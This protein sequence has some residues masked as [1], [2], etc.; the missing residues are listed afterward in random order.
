MNVVDLFN[1]A[2]KKYPDKLAII[3]KNE[4]INFSDLASKVERTAAY[5]E[6]KGIGQGDRVLVFVPMSIDL[7]RIVLALFSRGATAVFLDQWVSK[8]RMELCCEIADCKGF[9]G[10]LKSRIFALFSSEL[11]RIPLKLKMKGM[12]QK[13]LGT[14]DLPSDHPALITFTTG[15]TGRPK[16]ANR[17]HGF[18]NEQFDALLDEIQPKLEDVDMP[19]LPIVLFM[20]LGFGCTSVIADLKMTKPHKMQPDTILKQ[21]EENKVNRITASPFV[22]SRLSEHIIENSVK[23]TGI[24]KIFTG[25]APVFPS[26]A[27]VFSKAFPNTDVHIV[28]GSTEVEPISSLQ[29]R[30]LVS[31]EQEMTIGLPVGKVYHKTKIKI[32]TINEGALPQ[33]SVDDLRDLEVKEGEIG[34]IIVS[35][36]HVLKNYY[37]SEDA[38][39]KNKIVVN[40]T[41]W[42]RTGDSGRLIDHTLFLNGRCSQL[43]HHQDEVI[44]PFIVENQLLEIEGVTMGT[45]LKLDDQLILVLETDSAEFSSGL[46]GVPY[47]EV[48]FLDQIPRDPRHNSKIDY[49]KLRSIL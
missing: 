18:L 11:R 13:G 28:Y 45:L 31:R 16:A 5:F 10:V 7:Y 27:K 33:L 49:A 6:R 9:I 32:I 44:S 14:L 47:D 40:D 22:I 15:S 38:F 24:D 21:V 26:R 17:T 46:D 30:E 42:H 48:I 23:L 37:N 2:A 36:P 8:K 35:G 3:D 1:K 19:M 39:R 12:E 4:A 43:I 41:V 20:N 34:E 29:A 25:G